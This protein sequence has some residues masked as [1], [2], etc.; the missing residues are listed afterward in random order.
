M[1]S[2]LVKYNTVYSSKL[3]RRES[4]IKTTFK[5]IFIWTRPI[6]YFLYYRDKQKEKDETIRVLQNEIQRQELVRASQERIR[7]QQQEEQ[8][9]TTLEHVKRIIKNGNKVKIEETKT[10]E[11]NYDLLNE[12]MS[13]GGW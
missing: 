7:R 9:Q 12:F 4:G 3:V 2:S 10:C 5:I 6:A 13:Q 8:Q 11:G 1:S